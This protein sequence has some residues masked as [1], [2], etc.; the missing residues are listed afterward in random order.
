MSEQGQSSRVPAADPKGPAGDDGWLSEASPR[1][2]AKQSLQR[3]RSSNLLYITLA[4]IAII[5]T[6]AV[7]APDGAFLTSY[8]I[9]NI[10]TDSSLVLIFAVGATIVI[11]SGGLDLSQGSVATFAAVVTVEAMKRLSEGNTE[12]WLII[13]AGAVVAISSGAAWG[14]LNGILISRLHLNSFIVTLGTFGAALGVARLITGGI[15][16]TGAPPELTSSIGLGVWLGIPVPFIIAAAAAIIF[17]VILAYTRTGE[18]IYLVGS[19]EEAARRSGI[20]VRRQMFKV[21]V[22]SGALAGLAGFVDVARF[23]GASVS[24]GYF[25]AVVA[26]IA[27]VV[28]GGA[29]LVGGIGL[30]LGSVVGVFIPTVLSNGLIILEIQR[31]WQEIIVGIILVAAVGFDQWRRQ[32]ELTE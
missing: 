7:L 26:A 5:T 8:N 19:N 15:T 27:G 1:S 30:M 10:L 13:A 14:A 3:L 12:P 20:N 11:I 6:F 28:I 16:V 22:W 17:G 21:Y 32:R 31:F 18:Y 23:A 2:F 9:R 24:T 25:T 4:L 29:S